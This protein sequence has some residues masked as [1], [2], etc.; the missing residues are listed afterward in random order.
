M[1]V[2]SEC[3][4]SQDTLHLKLTGNILGLTAAG[5]PQPIGTARLD[6]QTVISRCAV[7]PSK[8]IRE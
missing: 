1:A 7:V 6:A 8:I 4:K 5:N 2:K 3:S